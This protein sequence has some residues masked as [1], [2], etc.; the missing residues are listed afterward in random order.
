MESVTLGSKSKPLTPHLIPSLAGSSQ[1]HLAFRYETELRRGW[2][3]CSPVQDPVQAKQSQ[4]QGKGFL[5]EPLL[6]RV[7]LHD[8]PS[9]E[10]EVLSFSLS[11]KQAPVWG[12]AVKSG[13][14]IP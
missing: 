11:A 9:G 14:D 7:L 3:S 13:L 5:Q 12:T 1:M 8:H 4:P 10:P 6:P 2:F